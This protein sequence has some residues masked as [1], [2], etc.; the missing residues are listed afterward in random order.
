LGGS[1]ASNKAE[2]KILCK[3]AEIYKNTNAG[4]LVFEVQREENNLTAIMKG[5]GWVNKEEGRT[6]AFLSF[7]IFELC[8]CI[9]Y[10]DKI[11]NH[12]ALHL[13]KLTSILHILTPPQP[14]FPQAQD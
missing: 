4:L 11:N 8:E 1:D 3:D 2:L 12:L 7:G 13:L 14:S 6:K 10:S 5:V 9:V